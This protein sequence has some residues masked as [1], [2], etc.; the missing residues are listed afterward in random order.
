MN[1]GDVIGHRSRSRSAYYAIANEMIAQLLIRNQISYTDIVSIIEMRTSP[2]INYM[3]FK[4]PVTWD[5]YNKLVSL[6]EQPLR[7]KGHGN[8]IPALEKAFEVLNETDN[9]NCAL[10]LLFL[11]DGRPSDHTKRSFTAMTQP[12]EEI[13]LNTVSIQCKSFKERLTFAAFGFAY[14]YRK[15]ALMMS[16]VDTA[17]NAG[18]H[19][20]F[21][22]GIDTE[23]LRKALHKM[24]TSLM[25]TKSSLSSLAGGSI[26]RTDMRARVERR[27]FIQDMSR[28]E[29]ERNQFEQSD[30]SI[31]FT[32][33][34]YLYHIQKTDVIFECTSFRHP[35]AKGVAIKKQFIG[36]GAERFTF[37]MT[38]VDKLGNPIG[39]QLVAKISRYE[40]SD[41]LQF[42]KDCSW[43]QKEARQIAKVFN[44]TLDKLKLPVP[45][46]SF[47]DV[48]FYLI[49]RE[50]DDAFLEAYLV[51][52]RLDVERYKKYNDNKGGVLNDHQKLN[53]NI[54]FDMEDNEEEEGEF[55]DEEVKDEHFQVVTEHSREVSR[56]IDDDVPQA[57]SHWSYIYTRGNRLVCDLQGVLGSKEFTLT[58]PSIHSKEQ[59]Y[60][61]KTDHGRLGQQRFFATHKCNPLCRVLKLNDRLLKFWKNNN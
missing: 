55:D 59:G 30:Y 26:L 5:L 14:D 38:E 61:G 50:V 28:A 17:K 1:E 53:V 51:E 22:T 16:M 20:V 39:E 25:S 31:H 57:F 19:G 7:G 35:K 29:D 15:F 21:S 43:T 54:P 6:A 40:E 10:G 4:E 32:V 46:V 18:C 11:S 42:H 2:T 58:D 49:Y 23:S 36:M 9:G 45:I 60:F 41:Q 13:I 56:I 44:T 8:Y 24:S 3:I 52:K 12:V 27:D 47:L 34:Q 37:E 33:K 48:S